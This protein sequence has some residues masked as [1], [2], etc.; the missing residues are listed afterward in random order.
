M[1]FTL[2]EHAKEEIVNRQLSAEL[3]HSVVTNP[4][5][6]VP[7]TNGRNVYQSRKLMNGKQFLVRV[8]VKGDVDPHIVITVY[9]TSQI[10]R[11]WVT[12]Q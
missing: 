6:I 11:Y 5:Q 4:E 10:E 2:S 3:V 8:V 1:P 7:S 12:A 9:R